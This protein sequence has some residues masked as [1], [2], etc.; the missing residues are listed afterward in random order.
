MARSPDPGGGREHLGYHPACA[1]A[2][3][4]AR[5]SPDTCTACSSSPPISPT[6]RN[7]NAPAHRPPS[8]SPCFT[9]FSWPEPLSKVRCYSPVRCPPSF[10]R[11]KLHW[12]RDFFLVYYYRSPKPIQDLQHNKCSIHFYCIDEL[13]R[14]SFSIGVPIFFYE[15]FTYQPFANTL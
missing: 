2:S 5:P 9:V 1:P 8:S 3:P 7:H 6:I 4:P 14:F 15:F 11:L 10:R 12:D 13:D